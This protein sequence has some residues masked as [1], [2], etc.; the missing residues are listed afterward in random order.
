MSRGWCRALWALPLA[1]LV[2]LC[3][4]LFAVWRGPS[5]LDLPSPLVPDVAT[6]SAPAVTPPSR[7]L[8]VVIDGL[9][10]ATVPRLSMLEQLARIGARAELDA[11][12]PTFSAPEYVAMLTGVP[13]R[14]SGIRSNATLRAAALDDVAASVRRA[15]GETVVVSDVVDWWPR[16]FPESFSHADRVALGSAPRT[17]AGE[18]PRARFAV[19]HLGR[20]DKAGHAAGALSQEYQEAARRA[21]EELAELLAHWD[22]DQ[23]AVVVVTDHGHRASGGHGGDEPDVRGSWLV[24]AGRGVKPAAE[25]SGRL[26]DVA[27]TLAALAGVPAPRDALGRTLV[28]LLDVKPEVRKKLAAD[29]DLRIARVSGR[30]DR[31]LSLFESEARALTYLRGVVLLAWLLLAALVFRR[32]GA[33]TR[34]GVGLGVALGVV[35]VLGFLLFFGAPSFSAARRMAIWVLGAALMGTVGMCALLVPVLGE[36]REKTLTPCG[37]TRALGAGWLGSLWPAALA[38]VFAGVVGPRLFAEPGWLAAGPMVAYAIA[39]GSTAAATV[40]ALACAWAHS[41]GR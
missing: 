9:S 15:G 37:A 5:A 6:P 36:L 24:A 10:T 34:R 40:G 8:L 41:R 38:F 13:P 35:S 32:G 14:D 19:V 30:R 23:G 25:L 28:E 27:P 26:R 21:D 33:A 1:E 31:V 39:A 4:L 2:V 22:R 11:E 3:G 18:L 16:L 17:A 29:D 12:P 7:V 20:V